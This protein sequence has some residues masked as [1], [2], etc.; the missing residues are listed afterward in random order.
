MKCPECGHEIRDHGRHGCL[1]CPLRVCERDETEAQNAALENIVE[2]L[3]AL[4]R[5]AGE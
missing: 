4:E 2:R 5:A 1:I 3:E